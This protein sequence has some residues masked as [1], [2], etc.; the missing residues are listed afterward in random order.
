MGSAR[1]VWGLFIV[2]ELI[3]LLLEVRI[4]GQIF[5]VLKKVKEQCLI[6]FARYF[7]AVLLFPLIHCSNR[8]D[9][10]LDTFFIARLN[11]QGRLYA[12]SSASG[13]HKRNA[14]ALARAIFLCED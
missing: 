12:P 6:L 8:V 7:H 10:A 14:A 3:E 11:P 13:R 5:D 2:D 9:R 4:A 1:V